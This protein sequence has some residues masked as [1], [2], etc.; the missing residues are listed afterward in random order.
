MTA[1]TAAPPPAPAYPTGLKRTGIVASGVLGSFVYFITLL[2]VS[3]ALP[4]LQGA[5]SAAPDQVAWL[6]TSFILGTTAVIT[7]T[8]W[9]AMRFGRKRV[10]MVAIMGFTLSSLLCGLA[11]SL[12]E[13]VIYRT[14]QGAF[15][16][17]LMPLGQAIVLDAFPREKNGLA[18]AIWSAGALSGGVFGPLVGGY[19]VEMFSWPWI[20]YI[21]LPIG[22]IA[23][24]GTWAFVP[25]IARD[26][27]RRLDW[28]GLIALLTGLT[29][30]TLMLNRGE[31]LE[32]FASTEIIVEAGI[33]VLAFYAYVTHSLT[34]IK[35]FLDLGLFRDRNYVL[36]LFFVSVF[37][38]IVIM[39]TFFLPILMQQFGGYSI[40]LSGVLVAVRTVSYVGWS[41][42]LS[43]FLDR[44]DSRLAVG[45][46]L[47]LVAGPTWTM[48]DWSLDIRVWDVVWTSLVQGIG[49]GFI[50]S[51]VAMIAFSTLPTH[52]R[53]EG[54]SLFHLMLN[55]SSSI[56]VA[57]M[58]YLL[59]R[60]SQIN[61]EILAAH[62][63]PYNEL[64]RLPG[65]SAVWD[66]SQP[67]TLAAI[68]SEITRQAGMIAF[69][70]NF[71]LMAIMAVAAIP[72]L[73]LVRLPRR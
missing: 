63:S 73:L 60:Y 45:I 42:M 33:T 64:F 27:E 57:G 4:Q 19:L 28:V 39:P 58:F 67:S 66:L 46:G 72:L 51:P 56:G 11:G 52:L 55:L 47:L 2:S 23:V 59:V 34:T 20:F 71:L 32:W 36:S 1:T 68:E 29:A 31:R 13:E 43:P 8:G 38:G 44:I 30:L 40:T 41:L 49:S 70:N 12:T 25:E 65:G 48:S 50:Y 54:M 6:L 3:L 9:L 14:L 7:A 37:G 53:T 61:H 18:T 62:V 15:G 22:V 35:P 17:P 26:R 69:N 10:F 5:F 16:A 24:L 21:N